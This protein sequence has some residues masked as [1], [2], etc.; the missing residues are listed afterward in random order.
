MLVEEKMTSQGGSRKSM[1]SI[2]SSLQGKKKGS[3]NGGADAGRKSL[4]SYRSM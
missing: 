4:T 3:E 1:T 2:N